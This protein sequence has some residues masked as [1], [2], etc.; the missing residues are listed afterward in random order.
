MKKL[1]TSKPFYKK[2]V[3]KIYC[4]KAN[5]IEHN[6]FNADWRRLSNLKKLEFD[7]IMSN[8]LTRDLQIRT[9]GDFCSIFCN[10]P[11]LANALVESLSKFVLVVHE[12][13]SDKEKEFLLNH[14][15]RKIACDHLPHGLYQYKLYLK[16]RMKLENRIN[17][18]KWT[19][20]YDTS[21]ISISKSTARWLAGTSYWTQTPFIYVNDSP[22][23]TMTC[24][25]LGDNL[26]SIEEYVLRTS[27]NS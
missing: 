22:M 3:Y 24:L 6:W 19:E 23:L 18:L 13:G 8:F 12:P 17:F 4:Y 10:D 27:I 14:Q 25:Y 20:R 9:E 26:K 5:G 1:K 2:W 16:T 11:L 15:A 7:S 21:K